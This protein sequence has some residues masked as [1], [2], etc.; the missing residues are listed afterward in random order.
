M[1]KSR[2]Q[3]SKLGKRLNLMPKIVDVMGHADRKAR[4][5]KIQSGDRSGGLFGDGIMRNKKFLK[6]QSGA[7]VAPGTK[8]ERWHPHRKTNKQKVKGGTLE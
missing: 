5:K 1:P 2:S 6:I 3:K 7:A 8:R 4:N